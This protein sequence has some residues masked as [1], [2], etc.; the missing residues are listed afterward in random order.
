MFILPSRTDTPAFLMRRFLGIG[1]G[2]GMFR[3][4]AWEG[5]AVAA[6]SMAERMMVE[7]SRKKH[8]PELRNWKYD[9]A[10]RIV[11]R[12]VKGVLL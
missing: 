6:G 12:I 8:A 4:G 10:I 11:I 5:P 1:G 7:R 3:G 2:L 9:L